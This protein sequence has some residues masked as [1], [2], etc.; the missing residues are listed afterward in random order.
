[1]PLNPPTLGHD[2]GTIP[3]LQRIVK[4]PVLRADSQASGVRLTYSGSRKHMDVTTIWKTLAI[5]A[6]GA[7]TACS[8]SGSTQAQPTPPA[9][10][11]PPISNVVAF[12]GDS[13]TFHWDLTQFDAGPTLNYGFGGDTTAGMLSRFPQVL[14]AAPG[15]VVI[16][17]GINDFVKLG[18]AGTNI[19][20]IKAMASQAKAAGIRVILCS[21]MPANDV[22]S[23]NPLAP[24][25]DI[26]A[27]ND[28]LLELARENGYL[29]ADYYDEFLNA[30]GTINDSLLLDGLHPNPAGYA[31]MWKVIAPLL[32]ED[33][34]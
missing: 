14:A 7:L 24:L 28:Q 20:S 31:V 2:G 19:D 3:A 27:F 30:D 13:I 34:S 1:M 23:G 15:V 6:L 22:A 11:S 21:V 16:L 12:M 10:V 5:L 29:Y 8:G 33:L 17:G 26:Q 9:Q 25:A 4:A 18:P 32:A